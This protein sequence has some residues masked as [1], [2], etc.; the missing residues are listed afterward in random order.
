MIPVFRTWEVWR[1]PR[2]SRA[3]LSAKFKIRKKQ[4]KYGGAKIISYKVVFSHLS[5]IGSKRKLS[6]GH[7]LL[8][9]SVCVRKKLSVTQCPKFKARV[10]ISVAIN[11]VCDRDRNNLK[12]SAKFWQIILPLFISFCVL[13][14]TCS[15][16]YL[17][18]LL[19]RLRRRQRRRKRK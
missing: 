18:L 12:T 3:R 11:P 19:R 8:S 17:L 4:N 13:H 7:Q 1:R 9:N 14:R 2:T 5:E 15:F 16:L 10:S 6:F